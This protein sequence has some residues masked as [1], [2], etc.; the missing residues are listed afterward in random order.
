MTGG[1]EA[2]ADSGQEEIPTSGNLV[3]HD[4]SKH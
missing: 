1:E 3:I 2:E 4:V